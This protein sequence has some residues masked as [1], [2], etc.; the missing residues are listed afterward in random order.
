MTSG[1]MIVKSGEKIQLV[2]DYKSITLLYFTLLGHFLILISRS[3]LYLL[4]TSLVLACLMSST[5]VLL[6]TIQALLKETA[7]GW[8]CRL[9]A[10]FAAVSPFI[11]HDV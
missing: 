5:Y 9:V 4:Y 3:V 11:P 6:I 7:L 2:S 8:T 1:V 10:S